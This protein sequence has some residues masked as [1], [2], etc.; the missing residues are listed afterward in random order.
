MRRL[1]RTVRFLKKFNKNK[2]NQPDK[3]TME[4]PGNRNVHNYQLSPLD[5]I[6]IIIN[7]LNSATHNLFPTQVPFPLLLLYLFKKFL[8]DGTKTSPHPFF[9]DAKS[10][11]I[12][13]VIS[14]N[15]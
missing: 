6:L 11:H 5:K 8:G 1:H 10:L 14:Q 15:S 3:G 7:G 9:S 4:T 2:T 13:I 12:L